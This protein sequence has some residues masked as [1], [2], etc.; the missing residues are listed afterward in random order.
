MTHFNHEWDT[1]KTPAVPMSIGDRYYA[2]DLNDDFNYLKHLPYESIL[3]GR[4]AGVMIPPNDSYDY[5]S[6]TLTLSNGFGVVAL[7]TP[8]V[9]VS[10]EFVIPPKTVT[11]KRFERVNFS[12]TALVLPNDGVLHY[13][14][15]TPA[16]RSLL[17]RTK[18]LF[19]EQY[20]SRIKYDGVITIQN[21]TPTSDQ[22]LVGICSDSEYL[23]C[24]DF[25]LDQGKNTVKFH[26]WYGRSQISNSV[27]SSLQGYYSSNTPVEGS[28][29]IDMGATTD[30]GIDGGTFR[31]CTINIGTVGLGINDG[32]FH[33][34]NINIDTTSTGIESGTFNN[35][36]IYIGTAGLGINDGNFNDCTINV[37]NTN[38][39]INDGNFNNCTIKIGTVTYTGTGT[40]SGVFNNCI[41]DIDNADI[42]IN[43]GNFSNTIININHAD[44]GI[45]GGDFNN[46][47]IKIG[48]VT[49]T[50]IDGNFYN[51]IIKINNMTGNAGIID[52]N[53]QNCSV[54]IYQPQ[55]LTGSSCVKNSSCSN[56]TFEMRVSSVGINGGTYDNCKFKA[57]DASYTTFIFDG[58]F[59]HCCFDIT[60]QIDNINQYISEVESIVMYF[61]TAK[62][63][64]LT[65]PPTFSVLKGKWIE[66]NGGIVRS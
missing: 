23:L 5:N 46:C 50:G 20:A 2:Q 33:D 15:A 44:A 35:C 1:T 24:K 48:T 36:I 34:C 53:L 41:I 4:N 58:E 63:N 19:S 8:V 21:S 25:V 51:C 54:W 18:S 26:K 55:G 9:D 61:V 7:D 11:S 16:K 65:T 47:T 42:G 14:V 39:G 13:I 32:T 3:Q 62:F 28:I 12:S 29:T 56:C 6:H 31:N 17:Q 22:I 49:D 45:D 59:Y 27:Y 10:Q 38:T 52:S 43:D 37:Y 60:A 30:T 64:P 40:D 57:I 66:V